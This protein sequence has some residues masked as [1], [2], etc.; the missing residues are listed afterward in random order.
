MKMRRCEDENM[1]YRPPLLE[2]PC[3]Q[4]LSGKTICLYEISTLWASPKCIDIFVSHGFKGK[5]D[6]EPIMARFLD[7]QPALPMIFAGFL[8][9][10]AF[11]RSSI[12][13]FPKII[14]IS[15][16]HRSHGKFSIPS[17][18]FLRRSI[19]AFRKRPSSW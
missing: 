15:K 3:A 13:P 18:Q 6:T 4:T 11:K 12:F 5:R 1:F 9:I 16:R 10:L 14:L 7:P 8:R 19:H 2:E 17:I